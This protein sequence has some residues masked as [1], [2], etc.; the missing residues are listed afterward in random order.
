MVATKPSQAKPILTKPS[1][2][3]EIGGK[4]V[5]TG[6]QDQEHGHGLNSDEENIEIVHRPE[7]CKKFKLTEYAD[8][9]KLDPTTIAVSVIGENTGP[10]IGFF[11]KQLKIMAGRVGDAAACE[12]FKEMLFRYWSEIKSG[13]LPDSIGA[14]LTIRVKEIMGK[15]GGVGK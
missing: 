3:K 14:G 12:I 10:G 4:T 11:S 6:D 2:A 5:P 8:F 7:S 15:N 1:Q 9:K 13:E